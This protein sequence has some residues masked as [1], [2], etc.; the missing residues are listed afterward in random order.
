MKEIN[1][2]KKE[3]REKMERQRKYV[4][5]YRQTRIDKDI[6]SQDYEDQGEDWESDHD[7]EIE[8]DKK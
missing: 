6:F 4:Y 1:R 5:T 7:D 3:E 2:M 8:E